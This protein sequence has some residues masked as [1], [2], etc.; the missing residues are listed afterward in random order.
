MVSIAM[1][2]MS[3]DRT[4][5]IKCHLLPN[6]IYQENLLVALKEIPREVFL[7]NDQKPFAYQ[8]RT[9]PLPK[10]RFLLSPLALGKL[11]QLAEVSPQDKILDVGC[12]LGY[13]TTILSFMTLSVIG[14]EEDETLVEQ[15]NENLQKMGAE[16]ARVYVKELDKGYPDRGPYDIILIQGA[17][18]DFPERLLHQLSEDGGRLVTIQNT[19][20]CQRSMIIYRNE[21]TFTTDLGEFIPA[22]ALDCLQ[23]QKRFYF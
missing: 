8:D 4:N 3:L 7:P 22:P 19:P 20:P 14:I 1:P 16:N 5:M 11:I 21:N 15:A 23:S 9:L 13:S 18:S 2:N 10:G 12:G 17:I 6:Q